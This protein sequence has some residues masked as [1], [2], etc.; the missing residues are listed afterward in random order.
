VR[1]GYGPGPFVAAHTQPS[2]STAQKSIQ[3]WSTVSL[4]CNGIYAAA[5][6][7]V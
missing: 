1:L 6:N 7:E 2:R 3:L 5:G 4:V